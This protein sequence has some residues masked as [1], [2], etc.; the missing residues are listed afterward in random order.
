MGIPG[1]LAGANPVIQRS[2][3]GTKLAVFLRP[4]LQQLADSRASAHRGKWG[5]LIP[6]EK[7][8]KNYKVKTCKKEQCSM[9]VLYFD[10][11]QGRQV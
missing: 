11:N 5:Q 7:W 8:T 3:R 6:L 4:F 9:F 2:P 10:C 1:R